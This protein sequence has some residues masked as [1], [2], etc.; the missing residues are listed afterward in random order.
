MK[1][2]LLLVIFIICLVV[3]SLSEQVSSFRVFRTPVDFI[4]TKADQ[5]KEDYCPILATGGRLVESFDQFEASYLCIRPEL[6]RSK[7]V[8]GP[9]GKMKRSASIAVMLPDLEPAKLWQFR[10]G[11]KLRS[12][13]PDELIK[14][15]LP[16]KKKMSIELKQAY[17]N[18]QKEYNENV[19]KIGLSSARDIY[20]V[21]WHY[22]GK[23][24]VEE[25]QRLKNQ[26]VF[27]GPINDSKYSK[28]VRF[29]NDRPISFKVGK[30]GEG[31]W[32]YK[33]GLGRD[34]IEE[35]GN[36]DNE[37]WEYGDY[38]PVGVKIPRMFYYMPVTPEEPHQIYFSC[39]W[40]GNIDYL[41][42]SNC[43]G[44]SLFDNTIR[45]SFSLK[46]KRLSEYKELNK[47]VRKL[48]GS[49]IVEKGT[50]SSLIKKRGK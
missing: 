39:S 30:Y 7:G 18:V 41:V 43:S 44:E 49:L 5:T 45:Y 8:D 17:L 46:R 4:Y 37:L 16:K 32:P 36:P 22:E 23:P 19:L 27:H 34:F 38:S 15:E 6:L 48:I 35:K 9:K 2:I 24:E 3:A 40:N 26:G 10:K 28:M 47:R 50:F 1:G 14:G 29:L 12:E 11:Q 25:Q 31:L 21:K 20:T 33:D 42:D 13:F